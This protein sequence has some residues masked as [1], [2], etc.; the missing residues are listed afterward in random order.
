MK[1]K[2]LIIGSI[3]VVVFVF[4]YLYKYLDDKRKE[5]QRVINEIKEHYNSWIVTEKTDLYC[6]QKDVYEICGSIDFLNLE[7]ENIEIKS[8]KDQYFK[9]KDKD[10]YLYYK[11]VKKGNS[12]APEV[13]SYLV[14]NQNVKIKEKTNLYQ[15]E[16]IVLNIPIAIDTPIL[17]TDQDRYYISY[18]GYILSVLKNEVEIY[19]TENKT[20]IEA[21][22]IPIL[23][24]KV[25]DENNNGFQEQMNY[26]KNQGYK[27]IRLEEYEKWQND[28]IKL[29]EKSILLLSN[30]EL[31]SDIQVNIANNQ[32]VMNNKVSEKGNRNSYVVT[33]TTPNTQL[34]KMLKG[35]T[36]IIKT[37][38]KV[39]VL[40]YHFFYNENGQ[41]CNES[42]CLPISKFEQQLKY[43]KDNNYYTLS[44]EEFRAWMYKEIHIPE[45]SVLITIDDGAMGTG[46]HNGNHL[47]PLLEK[48]QSHATLFLITGWWDIENYRSPYLDV[49]SHTYDMHKG[50]LCKNQ[51]RGAQLL[52]ST[53]DQVMKDLEKSV[54]ITQSKKA[55]CFPFYA[56]N[57]TAIEQVKRAGFNLAFVGGGYKASQSSNKY[58]IPRYP[59]YKDITLNQ[60]IAMIS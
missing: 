37:E 32:F 13:S 15:N 18:F 11:T 38:Q 24:Y 10:L 47:I 9:I 57:D 52:C 46:K 4:C 48:Y 21:T 43:L 53:D 36:I 17:Y 40:N 25:I 1:K 16:T 20:D 2:L 30:Q 60:F 39:A 31:N 33:M 6:K 22:R 26:I 7:L 34:E 12:K 8:T 44:I 14:W 5:E 51:T 50:N 58:K 41:Q 54:T 56:Y 59:I 27:T 29:P 42:I 35:E 3:I 23:Y 28:W 19:D 55:F 45:K 49:E